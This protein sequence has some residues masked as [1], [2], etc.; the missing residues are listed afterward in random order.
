[1]KQLFLSLLFTLAILPV[2][3]QETT[4]GI[5]RLKYAEM[6][7]SLNRLN[8]AIQNVEEQLKGRSAYYTV[9]RNGQQFSARDHVTDS[10]S[11][12]KW[13]LITQRNSLLS[14]HDEKMGPDVHLMKAGTMIQRSNNLMFVA[15]AFGVAGGA[16]LGAGFGKD[17]TLLKAVGIASSAVSLACAIGSISCSY[18][19]GKELKLAAGS[20]T[21]S[22]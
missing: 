10:L 17:K 13:R 6:I 21:Y 11:S 9:E 20:I 18:K 22:F 15:S 8:A 16:C 14:R 2:N 12:M 3:A 19:S 1:M 4:Y 7:D 5:I